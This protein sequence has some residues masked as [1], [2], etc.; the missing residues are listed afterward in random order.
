[1][2]IL[3]RKR[4]ESI[5]I[6]GLIKVTVVEVKG[7][8]VRIGIEAPPDKKIYREEIFLQ[9]LEENRRAADTS[10][11]IAEDMDKLSE[12]WADK[13][14]DMEEEAPAGGVARPR[15]SSIT[16]ASVGRQEIPVFKR[17]KKDTDPDER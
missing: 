7:N 1:M 11:D 4:S 9:I 6:D 8:Q 16:R 12:V 5:I 14:V 17:R 3:T 2:L 15:L 10:R 13:K